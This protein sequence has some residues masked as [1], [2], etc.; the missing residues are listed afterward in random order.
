MSDDRGEIGQILV[1]LDG[2]SVARSAA[3]LAVQIASS[4]GLPIRGLNVVSDRLVMSQ[5]SNYQEELKR[6]P[7]LTSRPELVEQFTRQ[8]NNALLWLGD[9]CR[10][11]N[12]PLT[13]DI[14]FGGVPEM[15][16]Q[17]ARQSSLIA[18]GRRGYS[19]NNDPRHIGRNFRVVAQQ[20][21]AP[22]LAGGDEQKTVRRVLL[23]YNGTPGA[24]KALQW[25]V[26]QQKTP[27]D[28]IV[29]VTVQPI[30]HVSRR[31]LSKLQRELDASGLMGYEFISRRGLPA[32]RIAIAAA[33]SQADLIVMGSYHHP[34]LLEWLLGGTVKGVLSR[35]RLP[36]MLV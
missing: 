21:K 16:L 15:L 30:R 14:L 24:R 28:Q 13:T 29:V 9:R 19:H 5:Y 6:N 11:Q 17:E 31:R 33:E 27:F 36:V 20:A 22:V 26:R 32:Y 3:G 18:M 2:S 12:V 23:A 35:T 4:R 25:L 34:I 8:G 7:Q 10:E 1:A